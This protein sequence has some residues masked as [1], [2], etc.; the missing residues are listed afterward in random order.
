MEALHAANPDLKADVFASVIR[1][2]NRV[3]E[4]AHRAKATRQQYVMFHLADL[5]TL[6]E[7][8]P[9]CRQGSAPRAT[10]LAPD[11]PDYLE[12]CARVNAALAAQAVFTIAGEILYGTGKWDGRGSREPS[13]SLGVRLRRLAGR[14]SSWTWTLCG[15]R[16]RKRAFK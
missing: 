6:V 1:L 4:E 15:P 5:A 3:F 16:S 11:A 14:A 9:R 12:H 7:T 8:E 2:V 10:T 13:W